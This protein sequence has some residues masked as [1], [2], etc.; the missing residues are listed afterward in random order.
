MNISE[1]KVGETYQYYFHDRA[2]HLRHYPV[3]VIKINKKS[4]RVKLAGPCP[5]PIYLR[6]DPSELD[7]RQVEAFDER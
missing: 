6:V 2:G 1:I 7:N 5:D 3:D 4:V